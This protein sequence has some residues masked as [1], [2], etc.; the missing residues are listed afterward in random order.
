M[1]VVTCSLIQ[2]LSQ[3]KNIFSLFCLV[4][5]KQHTNRTE[6]N[7]RHSLSGTRG[8]KLLQKLMKDTYHVVWQFVL[9]EMDRSLFAIW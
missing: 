7:T 2:M 6:A 3:Y 1:K 8:E 5:V 9:Y 4:M